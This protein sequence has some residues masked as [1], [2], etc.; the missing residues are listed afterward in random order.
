MPTV[1]RRPAISALFG[2]AAG[3]CGGEPWESLGLR[4]ATAGD[5]M[6]FAD[7]SIADPMGISH[8][9]IRLSDK[10]DISKLRKLE[11]EHAVYRVRC[12]PQMVILM[13]REF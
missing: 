8:D 3:A 2:V 4:A 6:G 1:G 9:I 10:P 7:D 5:V 13:E 11:P 12:T